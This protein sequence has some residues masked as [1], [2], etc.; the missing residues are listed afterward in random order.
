MCVCVYIYVCIYVYKGFPGGSVGK[1]STCNVGDLGS[2]PG[3]WIYPEGGHENPLQYSGLENLHGQRSL[4]DCSPWG[5]KELNMTEQLSTAQHS[6]G[7]YLGFSGGAS[8]KEPAYQCRRFKR[9][10]FNT[11]LRKIL[12]RRSWQLTPVFLR[13]KSH[14]Q[15]PEGHRVGHDWGDLARMHRPVVSCVKMFFILSDLWFSNP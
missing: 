12:W 4:V 14:G 13:G 1:E 8:G 9:H 3:L 7:L 15:E 10:R 5:L 6:T 2:I 11:W